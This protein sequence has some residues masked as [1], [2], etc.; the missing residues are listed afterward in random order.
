MTLRQSW[1]FF[2]DAVDWHGGDYFAIPSDCNL[3]LAT[4]VGGG[5]GGGYTGGA[6]D[7]GKGG[8]SASIPVIRYP[9]LVKPNGILL[10]QIG[11]GCGDGNFA[12]YQTGNYSCFGA[13]FIFGDLLGPEVSDDFPFFCLGWA[14]YGYSCARQWRGVN[15]SGSTGNWGPDYPQKTFLTPSTF[16]GAPYNVTAPVMTWEDGLPAATSPTRTAGLQAIGAAGVVGSKFGTYGSNSYGR[17]AY[18]DGGQ[19][20]PGG[21]GAGNIFGPGGAGGSADVNGGIGGDGV[22]FGTGGGGGV[23]RAYS[24]NGQHGFLLLEY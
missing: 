4:G 7:Q 17:F 2:D 10:I 5:A 24:G 8:G 14:G 9:L 11:I 22:G 6:Q 1:Y 19:M 23:D 13:T 21:A 12:K 15:Q 20:G 3:V 16:R 18:S